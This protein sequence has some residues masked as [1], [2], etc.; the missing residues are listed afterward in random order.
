MLSPMTE[1]DVRLEAW[2]ALLLA[3]SAALRVIEAEVRRTGTV[4]L[5][6]YDVLLELHAAHEQAA[7]D[8][9]GALRMQ[10]LAD[11]VVL[12]RTRV[13]R[14][15]DEMAVAGLVRKRQDAED[16]R[17]NWASIT[18]DGVY[19][20]EQTAPAYRRSVERHFASLLTE[21]EARV[22]ADALHRVARG[23]GVDVVISSH[24]PD[25]ASGG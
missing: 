11:R 5:S 16:K 1:K 24:R 21:D 9:A 13:S 18:E 10:E 2:R 17:V 19:A 4:P 14:L 15:V 8:G 23:D 22:I 20:L 6:W 3:H 7:S 12:S 25:R